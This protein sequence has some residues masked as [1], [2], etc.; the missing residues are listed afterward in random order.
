MCPLAQALDTS[1]SPLWL[2]SALNSLMM[3][4]NWLMCYLW[5]LNMLISPKIICV[6]LSLSLSWN[7]DTQT[8]ISN[9]QQTTA[10]HIYKYNAS[11][12]DCD[13]NWGYFAV[14]T[15][16][17]LSVPM[18][19]FKPS[20]SSS[21]TQH[22]VAVSLVVS[23]TAVLYNNEFSKCLFMVKVQTHRACV[24]SGHQALVAVC[25]LLLFLEWGWRW[26]ADE[27]II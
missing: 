13:Y 2:A 9:L 7:V 8:Q 6:S 26:G 4:Y 15:N 12:C 14:Y 17:G 24:E 1:T 10:I 18:I 20:S 22:K 5:R 21:W 19:S 16:Q 11:K 3:R 27:W 25:I 23:M